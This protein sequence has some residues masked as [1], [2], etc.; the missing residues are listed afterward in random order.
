MRGQRV[1]PEMIVQNRVAHGYVASYAFIEA[2][3]GED[4]VGG[5]EVL[6][7]VQPLFFERVEFRVSPDLEGAAGG[8]AAHGCDMAVIVG[9]GMVDAQAG[10]DRGLPWFGACCDTAKYQ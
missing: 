5:C 8:G 10:C 2:S 9:F 3:R 6:F 1:K 4:A 7:P